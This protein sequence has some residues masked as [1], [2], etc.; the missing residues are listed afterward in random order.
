MLRVLHCIHSLHGGGAETQLGLLAAGLADKGIEVAIFFVNG[1]P[2]NSNI[3]Y[4]RCDCNGYPRNLLSTIDRA[5]IEFEPDV[6][7]AWV[8]AVINVAALIAARRRHVPVI[9]SIRNKREI[10]G[11]QRLVSYMSTLLLADK[12]V[13]NN[14]IEQSSSAYK[15]L[16]LRKQGVVISNA[17]SVGYEAHK[18]VFD[19]VDAEPFRFI[20]VGRL[21]AQKNV[22]VLID[23]L[24]LCRSLREWRLDIYG[25]G[26]QRDSLIQMTKAKGLQD[27]ISFL[28][29]H[30]AIADKIVASDLLVL[31]SLYE[32]MPNVVVEALAL[33]TQALVSDIPAHTLLFT[34]GEVAFF[35]SNDANSLADSLDSF[36]SGRQDFRE[37][38][39]RGDEFVNAR[40][41]DKIALHYK[42]V[43]Q[44][45]VRR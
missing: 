41:V 24:S 22:G 6:I 42:E 33:K 14:P 28:G 23:A 32:G 45:V 15:Y 21:T 2:I 12:V 5:I 3:R 31:P 39:K 18:Q 17:V 1:E 13:S 44:S 36:L 8:P 25:K 4:F 19:A 27:R 20:Y 34:Q 43:Y 38:L 35:A 9:S 29:Y 11:L 30:D 37:M 16:Y 7:H 26:E 40:T 10:D